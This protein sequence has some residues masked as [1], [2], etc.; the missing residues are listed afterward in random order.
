M[1]RPALTNVATGGPSPRLGIIGP[2]S[3][4][5]GGIRLS[6]TPERSGVPPGSRG[7]G[8]LRSGV[9]AGVFGTSGRRNAGHCAARDTEY[10]RQ[11]VNVVTS[12]MAK[13]CIARPKPYNHPP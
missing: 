10:A 3:R 12:R 9:P 2:P 13:N 7:A 11:K 5:L 8:A 6:H 1:L 4:P